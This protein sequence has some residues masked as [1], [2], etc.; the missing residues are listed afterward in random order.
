MRFSRPRKF[1]D[2]LKTIRH[3][4]WVQARLREAL[5]LELTLALARGPLGAVV[6]RGSGRGDLDVDDEEGSGP[7]LRIAYTLHDREFVGAR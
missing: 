7:V 2:G 4:A 5:F 6:G 1:R 3:S